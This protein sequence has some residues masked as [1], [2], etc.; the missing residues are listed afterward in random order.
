MIFKV[1]EKLILSKSKIYK[2]KSLIDELK[3]NE[4]TLINKIKKIKT[5]GFQH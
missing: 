5:S 3:P 1:K 4:D 2:K